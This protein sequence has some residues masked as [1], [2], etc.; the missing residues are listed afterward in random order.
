MFDLHTQLPKSQDYTVCV[1]K[2]SLLACFNTL[3]TGMDNRI[4]S[5]N[6]TLKSSSNFT[7]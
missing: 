4:L 5:K 6:E 1:S 7:N 3:N 2:Y